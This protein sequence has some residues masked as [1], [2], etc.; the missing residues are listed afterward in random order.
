[1]MNEKLEHLW[2]KLSLTEE[3]QME[4]HQKWLEEVK[5]VGKNCLIGKL[6]LNRRVNMVVM[7]N[8]LTNIWKLSSGMFIKEVGCRLFIFQFEDNME[9]ERVLQR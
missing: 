3:E 2:G 5:E 1:M 9:K 8:V 7:K 4:V 6:V